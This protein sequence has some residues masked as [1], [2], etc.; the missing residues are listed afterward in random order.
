MCCCG[1]MFV[2]PRIKFDAIGMFSVALA[3]SF[4]SGLRICCKAGNRLSRER[5]WLSSC[6]NC[7]LFGSGCD[8]GDVTDNADG[9]DG[10]YG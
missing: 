10:G 4:I 7:A 1:N 6:G 3:S 9:I 2:M 5:S 8:G